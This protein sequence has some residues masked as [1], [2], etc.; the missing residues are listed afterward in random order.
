MFR[1]RP[2]TCVTLVYLLRKVVVCHVEISQ[3]TMAPHHVFG[4]VG[5]PLMNGSLRQFFNV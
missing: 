1:L 2:T 5:N 3:S 4:I